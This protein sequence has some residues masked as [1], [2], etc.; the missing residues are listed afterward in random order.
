MRRSP[1]KG[2]PRHGPPERC[3]ALTDPL[4]LVGTSGYPEPPGHAGTGRPRP[5]RR[6]VDGGPMG[7]AAGVALES[8]WNFRDPGRHA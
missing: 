2:R 5:F 4:V 3:A 1:P 8:L 6:I 7:V